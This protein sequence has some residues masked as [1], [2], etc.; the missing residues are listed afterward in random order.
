MA[1][2]RGAKQQ[3]PARADLSDIRETG[4]KKRLEVGKIMAESC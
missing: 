2:R 3:H 4:G 1:L